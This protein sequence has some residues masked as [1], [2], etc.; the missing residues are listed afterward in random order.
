M[1]VLGIIGSPRKNG[2]TDIVLSTVL[3]NVKDTDIEIEKIYLS[4]YKINEC[5]ACEMCNE[6]CKCVIKDDMQEIYKKLE[7]ADALVL[8]SPTYYYNV[9]GITK[10]FIDRLYAYNAFDN[11]DR[12]VWLS[13]NEIFGIKYAVTVAICEQNNYADMGVTSDVMKMTIQAIGYRV[14][15]SVKGLF[16][17]KKGE[18]NDAKDL[19]DEAKEAGEK[20]KKTMR[21]ANKIKRN[22]SENK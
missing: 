4:D 5:I 18:A 11:D 12:S 17:F 3:E 15:K 10:M 1:K 22:L 16:L 20:L 2:N 6:T 19:L 13:P 9:S 14:V 8:G 21:L 7:E